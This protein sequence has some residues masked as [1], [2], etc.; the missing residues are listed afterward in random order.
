MMGMGEEM[1]AVT[2]K[3][4]PVKEVHAWDPEQAGVWSAR[5]N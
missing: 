1:V 4:Q 2:E 3:P 5:K